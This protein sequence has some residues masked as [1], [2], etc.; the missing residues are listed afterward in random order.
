MLS[1]QLSMVQ[2]VAEQKSPNRFSST[3]RYVVVVEK[4]PLIF[5]TSL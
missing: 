5:K 4:G 3:N 1:E 2:S